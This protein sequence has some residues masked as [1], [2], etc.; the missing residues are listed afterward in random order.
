MSNL[1]RNCQWSWRNCV[2]SARNLPAFSRFLEIA[3][4]SNGEQID[5]TSISKD[6]QVP[7]ST[8]QEYF[9]ILQETFLADEVSVWKRGVKRKTVETSKFYL[10]DSGVARR[11]TRRA[12]TVEGTPEYGHLFE[13]WVHHEIR[14]YL[15]SRIRDGV[16]NYWRTPS[17]TEV[18]FVVGTSAL[19]VKSA[20]T[21][22]RGDLKGLRA[23]A[24]E[25]AFARRIL[26]CREPLPRTQDGVEILPADVFVSR[27]WGDELIDV[28]TVALA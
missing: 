27:L 8:V 23:I 24:E 3:A 12:A 22:D 25:G 6:A 11:L 2:D 15:D 17:G 28:A 1:V 10:F 16:I 19:E 21:V 7:R 13:T 14:S 5:Y 26:V 20:K 9:K 18:D 4:L